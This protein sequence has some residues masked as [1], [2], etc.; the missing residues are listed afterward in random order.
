MNSIVAALEYTER[1]TGLS[2]D[3]IQL[4]SDYWN[5]IR[6]IYS[7]FESDLQSGTAEV[8]KYEIPGGQ[9][10]NFKSQVDSFGIGHKFIEVKEMYLAVN[11]MVGDIV[12][13]TP[14]SKMVGDL[15]IFMVKNDLTPENILT[16]GKDMAFPD[17][18][19]SYYEGMMGQPIGGFS[20]E[21]QDIVLKGKTPITCRPGELLPAVDFDKLRK[22][23]SK[24]MNVAPSMREVVSYALYPKVYE[25]YLAFIKKYGDLSRMESPLFFDGLRKGTPFDVELDE[26]K[27]FIIE[28][29]QIGKIDSDAYRRVVF[30]VNGNRREM[31]ILDRTYRAEKTVATTQMVDPDNPKEVGAGIPGSVSKI[32]VKEGD[33]V[34][35][36]DRACL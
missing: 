20:K 27:I 19:V 21:I 3:S 25:E 23:L 18:V 8:Y 36:R 30:E 24:K 1:D 16:R 2:R 29:I 34:L 31:T 28:L 7:Q 35:K 5:D 15:A 17:S 9:Y 6:P 26:G 22:D 14:S 32:L 12:K 13:V 4:I 11:L 10:S 33:A